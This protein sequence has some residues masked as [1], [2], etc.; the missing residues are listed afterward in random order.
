[1]VPCYG[2]MP[3]HGNMEAN[4]SVIHRY[5]H[6][7]NSFWSGFSAGFFILKKSNGF[8]SFRN[9]STFWVYKAFPDLNYIVCRLISLL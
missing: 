4:N 7:L 6:F 5:W 3:R 9:D 8:A 2:N 1:M